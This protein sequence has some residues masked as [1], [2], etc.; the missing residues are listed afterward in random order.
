MFILINNM[1]LS[2]YKKCPLCRKEDNFIILN[3]KIVSNDVCCICLDHYNNK[4]CQCKSC[5]NI[6]HIEC[7]KQ[8]KNDINNN[9]QQVS[10][11]SNNISYLDTCLCKLFHVMIFSLVGYLW[12]IVLNT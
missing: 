1:N 7:I 2:L 11:V 5:K 8:I 3:I 10:N 12:I 4:V 9:V 6:Y